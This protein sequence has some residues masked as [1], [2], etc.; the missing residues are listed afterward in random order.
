MSAAKKASPRKPAARKKAPARTAKP[1]PTT[2]PGKQGGVK[3]KAGSTSSDKDRKAYSRQAWAQPGPA[4]AA[5][6]P[7]QPLMKALR[8]EHR[9]IATV[10][11]LFSD[12]LQAIEAGEPVDA[13]VVY[14]VMD[15]MASWPDRYHHPREDLIYGRVAELDRRAAEDVDT[16][17]RD[18]DATAKRGRQLL[19]EIERWSEGEVKGAAIVKAGREYVGH[20]YEHMNVEEKVVFPHIESVLT[21]E[22]WRELAEDDDLRAVSVP[23]F[24]PRVQR[25]FRNL[26][27]RLR[28]GVRRR[29]ERGVVQEW[30][31]VEALMESLEV[32][33]LAAETASETAGDHLRT[34][35]DNSRE[36]FR[37]A[38]LSAPLRCSVNNMKLGFRLVGDMVDISR[39]TFD[40]LQR[41][42]RE[43]RERGELFED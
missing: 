7:E 14:E 38:P 43:R 42:N 16:L 13:H 21:L 28:R 39:E 35:L 12:Q 34:A 36:M 40:D 4:T 27:R 19:R 26:A 10:M 29:V 9:H 41:I 31:G 3:G 24:G 1:S 8:A 30:L 11:Q 37:E 2:A 25:E 15:Y 33:S 22:D 32:L 18:H 20:M 23:V 6:G 17:Q 5:P